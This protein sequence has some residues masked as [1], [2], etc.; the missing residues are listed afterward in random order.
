M[1][2]ADGLT[3]A[4]GTA[5]IELM[6]KAGA[7]VAEAVQDYATPGHAILVA[8][9][10]GNNGGDGLV[11]AR[12]LREAGWKVT[13]CLHGEADRLR[14]D[15]ALAL[16]RWD[17]APEPLA[18]VDPSRFGLVVDA[19]FGAGL[20]R[21]VDGEVAEFVA[22][23]NASGRPVIAVD[24]PSGI[25]GDTGQVKGS[26]VQATATVTFFRKKPGHLLLP[27]RAQCGAITVAD[28][29]IEPSVLSRIG[30]RTSENLPELWRL[31]FT[32]PALAGHKYDRGHVLAVS[33]P[34]FA[35]GACRLAAQAALRIGAGLVT[36]G[37]AEAALR[38][39]AAHVTAIMLRLMRTPA[40]LAG[41][42]ADARFRAAI[43]GPGLGRGDDAAAL[44]EAALASEA[45]LV[46]DADALTSFAGKSSPFFQ[47][48]RARAAPVVLTPH[49][50]EFARLFGAEPSNPDRLSAIRS[51][52]VRSGAVVVGKGADTVIA[53]PDGRA[54]I[55]ANAPPWLATAGAGDVLAG[56]ICGLLAQNMPAFEAACNAVWLHGAAAARFGPGLTAG[57]IEGILPPLLTGLTAT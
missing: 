24:L 9:G 10:P 25:D 45:S 22:K 3:I 17:G 54:A 40:E 21:D 27:G 56:M 37:G 46:L 1:A 16:Q 19:L 30:P 6:E 14:G 11:A 38:V 43:L 42:L 48:V 2:Q 39:H 34:E 28:I 51:A 44:V 4:D 31:S 55:N 36:I 41:I 52:S 7:A 32:R 35:T 47:A 23:V 50:G 33:G 12:L 57:D 15:A 53:A 49:D 26:A 18:R 29:G 20:A 8:C 5:G 13:V